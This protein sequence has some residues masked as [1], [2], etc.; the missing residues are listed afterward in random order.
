MESNM[1]KMK[2]PAKKLKAEASPKPVGRPSKYSEA[3]ADRICDELA[4]KFSMRQ[5]CAREGMPTRQSVDNWMS[6]KP[7]FLA[8]CARAR[9]DQADFI[10][11]D[12]IDIEDRTI[13]GEINPAAARAVLS[14]KQWRASKLAPKKY[15]DKLALGGDSDGVPLTVIVKRYGPDV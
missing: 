11:E 12:C 10:V 2:T 1:A 15:G 8:K 13:S 3:L 6:A 5:I 4:N 14:S 7:D 9:E